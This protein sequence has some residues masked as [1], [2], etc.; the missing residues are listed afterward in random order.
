MATTAHRKVGSNKGNARV[1]LEGDILAGQGWHRGD[2]YDRAVTDGTIRLTR[3]VD[4]RYR[5][6]GTDTRP[7]IDLAGAWLTAWAD[8]AESV[9]V[10]V[11]STG[12]RVTL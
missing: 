9:E 4:G 7:I 5:V 6:A 10:T 2:R 1:W 8:G 12:V 11:T 3:N